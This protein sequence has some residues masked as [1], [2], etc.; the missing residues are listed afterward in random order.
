V[1]PT[2][3]PS[4]TTT[5]APTP[6]WNTADELQNEYVNGKIGNVIWFPDFPTKTLAENLKCTPDTQS[7]CVGKIDFADCAMEASV[8]NK[9]M[10]VD[11][12]NLFL[13]VHEHK[14]GY[15][16]NTTVVATELSRCSYMWTAGVQGRV[17]RGCGNGAP[18]SDEPCT[19][20]FS[21]YNNKCPSTG[22]TCNADSSEVKSE[23]CKDMGGPTN[24]PFPDTPQDI[25]CVIPGPA[26]NFTTVPSKFVPLHKNDGNLETMVAERKKKSTAALRSEENFVVIDEELLW[27]KLKSNPKTVLAIIHAIGIESPDIFEKQA[28]DLQTDFCKNFDDSKKDCVPLVQFNPTVDVTKERVYTGATLTRKIVV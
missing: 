23:I 2:P 12:D 26:M 14:V 27:E 15:V 20:P 19:D 21:A 28:I 6:Q 13:P 4:P 10:N 1:K 16:F 9:F 11:E 8:F 22:K 18:G 7:E 17:N 24:R 25:Q 3:A 5:H